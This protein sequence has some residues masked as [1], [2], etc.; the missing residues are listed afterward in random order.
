MVR[1]P[2]SWQ[3]DQPSYHLGPELAQPSIH[4][5]YDLPEHM[6]GMVLQL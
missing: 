6:K 2:E 5:I 4:T 3:V 1:M